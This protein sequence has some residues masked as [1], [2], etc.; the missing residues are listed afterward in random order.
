MQDALCWKPWQ[1]STFDVT[2]QARNNVT[3]GEY[4]GMLCSRQSGTDRIYTK[5]CKK[6]EKLG[7]FYSFLLSPLPP[8][9]EKIPT[10]RFQWRNTGPAR[11]TPGFEGSI[12]WEPVVYKN[13][14]LAEHSFSL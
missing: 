12:V 14:D 9:W 13:S 10:T 11:E 5:D 2:V 7:K 6:Y 3:I 8:A 1:K 4:D